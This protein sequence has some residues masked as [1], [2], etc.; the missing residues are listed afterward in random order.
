MENMDNSNNSILVLVVV[1][2]AVFFLLW[3]IAIIRLAMTRRGIRQRNKIIVSLAVKNAGMETKVRRYSSLLDKSEDFSSEESRMFAEL[4][5]MIIARELWHNQNIS[6]D[7]MASLTGINRR[8][9]D[10]ILKIRLPEGETWQTWIEG[11][12]FHEALGMIMEGKTPGN[13][14]T[15]CGYPSEKALDRSF[16]KNTGISLREFTEGI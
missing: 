11:F 3:L 16:R 13:V 15:A 5:D 4:E 10:D 1:S 14:A 7:D 9:L 2:A 6:R 8:Q 12:R